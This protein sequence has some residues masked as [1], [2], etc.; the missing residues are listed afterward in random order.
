MPLAAMPCL[1]LHFSCRLE[2]RAWPA[3]SKMATSRNFIL[4]PTHVYDMLPNDETRYILYCIAGFTFWLRISYNVRRLS[5]KSRDVTLLHP[6]RHPRTTKLH[7]KR[8]TKTAPPTMAVV[9][10]FHKL[11][12]LI[13][14]R[15]SRHLAHV[16][17]LEDIF[18]LGSRLLSCHEDAT[19]V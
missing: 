15:P 11:P 12:P 13:S 9:A 5:I 2:V 6:T 1:M 3:E 18:Y 4:S 19:A 7:D 10:D 14:R 8:H 17:P 16:H